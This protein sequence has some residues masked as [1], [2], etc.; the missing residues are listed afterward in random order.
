MAIAALSTF[1]TLTKAYHPA[2]LADNTFIGTPTLKKLRQY[3]IPAP[4][5]AWKQ[6]IELVYEDGEWYARGGQVPTVD[7]VTG[8][9]ADEAS[10]TL[11][12]YRRKV[13]LE[14]Q[15][16]DLQ[17]TEKLVDLLG[18]QVENATESLRMNLSA[19]LFTTG[20]SQMDTLSAFCDN[21]ATVGGHSPATAGYERWASHAMDAETTYS[22]PVSPSL[23]NIAKM[24]RSM[25][26]STGKMPDMGVVAEDY[27]DVLAADA[28]RHP[29]LAAKRDSDI[30]R[31]GFSAIHVLGVPIVSDR[32]MLGETWVPDQSTRADAKGYQAMFLDFK[33]CKLGYSRDRAFRWDE[34]GWR[35]PDDYDRY[36]NFFYFWGTIGGDKRRNQG[37]IYGVKL[38]QDPA[39]YKLGVVTLPEPA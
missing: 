34:K 13:L 26:G 30:L 18:A 31:W 23:N 7:T 10:Y 1:N 9:I 25:Q 38:D 2:V 8:E 21:V 6:S 19:A 22:V 24:L 36:L 29:E 33:H 12:Y 11:K 17:D 16:V 20:T 37:R 4:G 5:K 27:W 39:E 3:M 15:D 28:A 32:H 35:K 14:A